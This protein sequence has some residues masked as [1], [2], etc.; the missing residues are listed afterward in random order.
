MTET[1]P[2]FEEA[3]KR[4]ASRIGT[5]LEHDLEESLLLESAQQAIRAVLR[6][7]TPSPDPVSL[8]VP[9]HG[10]AKGLFHDDEVEP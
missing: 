3:R 7:Q 2:S 10:M 1:T 6:P 4:I 9:L 5:V 8:E